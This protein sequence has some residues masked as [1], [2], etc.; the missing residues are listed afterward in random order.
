M[1]AFDALQFTVYTVATTY[2]E[3]VEVCQILHEKADGEYKV[4]G[5][6]Y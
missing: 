3:L 1:G 4:L 5:T 6:G 2:G